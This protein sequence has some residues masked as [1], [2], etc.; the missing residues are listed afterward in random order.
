MRYLVSVFAA[1]DAQWYEVEAANAD[2]AVRAVIDR[3][4][5]GGPLGADVEIAAVPMP[6]KPIVIERLRDM[7]E[8]EAEFREI[9]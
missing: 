2:D 1:D 5:D 3:I 8:F 6:D 9:D 4:F 7:S